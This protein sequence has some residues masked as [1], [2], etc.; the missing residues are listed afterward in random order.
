MN[1]QMRIVVLFLFILTALAQAGVKNLERVTV[2]GSEY[3]RV[4][5]WAD[6]AGLTIYSVIFPGL[7]LSLNSSRSSEPGDRGCQCCAPSVHSKSGRS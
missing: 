2:S 6:N 4:A 5:E 3:V 1:D 7:F